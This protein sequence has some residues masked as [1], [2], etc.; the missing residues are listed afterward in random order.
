MRI[1]ATW[2]PERSPMGSTDAPVRDSK[3]GAKCSLE[4]GDPSRGKRDAEHVGRAAPAA[5]GGREDDPAPA[6]EASDGAHPAAPAGRLPARRRAPGVR[7]RT[8]DP[9]E[10]VSAQR[11]AG[12]DRDRHG[13]HRRGGGILV[14]VHGLE[15]RHRKRD[16]AS[17]REKQGQREISEGDHEGEDGA[18]NDTG[19]GAGQRHQKQRCERSG[20]EASGRGLDRRIRRFEARRDAAHHPRNRDHEVRREEGREGAGELDAARAGEQRETGQESD[21][22]HESGQAERG[23]QDREQRVATR[24][25]AAGQ[26]ERRRDPAKQ[27]RGGGRQTET[28]TRS[29]PGEQSRVV[30]EPRVPAEAEPRRRDRERPLPD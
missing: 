15:D 27:R 1:R 2:S 3:G 17:A 5:A 20:A 23:E 9:G 18:G 21:S 7:G 11:G 24:K 12:G 19:A 8:Q 26:A 30:G 29:E 10:P 25:R 13:A 14:A 4:I 16:R 22:E 28:D 6:P